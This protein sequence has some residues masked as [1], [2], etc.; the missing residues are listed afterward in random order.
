[1]LQKYNLEF[2]LNKE[3]MALAEVT[4]ARSLLELLRQQGHVGTK[5]GCAEGDCGACTVVMRCTNSDGEAEY[6]ALNSCLIAC[7]DVMGQ[8][9]ISVEGLGQKGFRPHGPEEMHP[10]QEAM[11]RQAGSQCGYCTP[12]FVMSLFAAYYAGDRSWTSLEGNLCRCTGYVPMQ[13]VLAELPEASEDDFRRDLQAP[14]PPVESYHLASRGQS[15]FKPTG[16]DELFEVLAEQPK[17]QLLA[18]GSD[19]MLE[20]H[21]G[22]ISGEVLVSL[23]AIAELQSFEQNGAG[24]T[25]GAGLKLS[26]L[27]RKLQGYPSVHEMLRWFAA[28]QIRNRATLGGNIA[29]ASPIGDM[30][31]VLLALDGELELRSARGLRRIAIKDFFTGYRR[32]VLEPQEIIAA[33]R[34]PAVGQA[35]TASYKVAK[36]GVDDISTVAASYRIE[37]DDAGKVELARL[38]Y[39]GV[40]ATAA[41]AYDAE[42][43]LI[44][45]AWNQ[46]TVDGCARVLEQSFA[47]L[48]DL[49][50]SSGYRQKLIANLFKKFYAERGYLS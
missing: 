46:E 43:F 12:G 26:E 1:M 15:F 48:S 25:I 9:V 38:A 10:V 19:V 50:A 23:E 29:T 32:S 6:R 45:R 28:R 20:L 24:V 8:E 18:G 14:V 5:E 40:A 44:G 36:R 35:L 13:K 30:P 4:P 7:G 2:S 49:R 22:K 17:A 16:L 33:V 34:I 3:A 11:V 42:S 47:P 41:R 39:G 37:L 31:V 21:L 27:E